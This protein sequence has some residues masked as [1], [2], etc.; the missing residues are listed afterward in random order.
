MAKK[1]AYSLFDV[2]G[3]ELEYMVVDKDTLRVSPT[4]DEL[5]KPAITTI[6]QPAREIGAR[7]AAILLDRIESGGN[8]EPVTLRLP[9]ALKIRDSSRLAR[10]AAALGIDAYG[11]SG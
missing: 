7:A 8:A 9:A 1:K 5:F 6:V 3:I 4:V 2:T 11:R 10:C